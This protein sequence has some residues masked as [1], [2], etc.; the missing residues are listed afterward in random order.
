M[1]DPLQR[2]YQVKLTLLATVM[3]V[4][5]LALL[6]TLRLVAHVPSLHWLADVPVAELGGAL[7][8][9]GLVVVAF[10][11][12]DG[13]DNEARATAR[14]HQVLRAEASAIRDAV[15]DGF[16]F[17]SED[18]A[19]VA[20]PDVLDQ[21]IS[22]S[23]ALRLG[24]PAFAKEVYDDI[25]DQAIRAS[26]RWHDA[27]ISIRLSADRRTRG[28]RAPV[29]VTTVEW[30]YTVIPKHSS[31]RFACV[32]NRAE[33]RE[34]GQDRADTSAWYLSPRTGYEAGSREGFELVQFC[35]NGEE[36]TI[37]RASR[38]TGQ[39]YTVNIGKQA[40]DDGLPVVI[41]YMYRTVVSQHGHLLHFDLE[42]PTRGVDI[43]L[44]YSD[45]D[46]AY[47]NVLDFI[48]SSRKTR[49]LHT[50]TTVPGRSVAVQFDGWVFPRSG[51]AF[52][53]ALDGE[54]VGQTRDSQSAQV[55][56]GAAS[57]RRIIAPGQPRAVITSSPSDRRT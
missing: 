53:W 15:I 12:I 20:T 43:Q 40:V 52:V 21:I 36:R 7:F 54:Q 42:Q 22:N 35:V 17:Q 13:Q 32:S 30:E 16:A 34:L 25:R 19:R 27:Q 26:E 9:T 57:R 37:S 50:P 8:T 39:V 29:F 45:C 4:A 55:R 31:R 18:L 3:T 10:N 1:R 51:V 11:Y 28:P 6:V 49:V 48:A 41:S 2:L 5:G 24:D 23:L 14:L 56:T 44:D 38:R 47:V 33:Y 46:I